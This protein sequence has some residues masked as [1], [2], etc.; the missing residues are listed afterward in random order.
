MSR[1]DLKSVKFK[2]V[3]VLKLAPRHED[4][5]G[6]GGMAPLTFS[7]CTRWRWLVSFTP[8]PFYLQGKS[9]QYPLGRRLGGAQRRFTGMEDSFLGLLQSKPTDHHSLQSS[10]KVQTA[11]T[12]TST[13]HVTL[14]DVPFMERIILI[15]SALSFKFYGL[16]CPPP[17]AWAGKTALCWY[18]YGCGREMG[19]NKN[20]SN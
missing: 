14:Q 16:W 3:P 8:R 10:S 11:W 6:S 5:L 4:V 15:Y 19:D 18:Y 13:P 12:A 17:L 7:F 20:N 9:S 1:I 2:V